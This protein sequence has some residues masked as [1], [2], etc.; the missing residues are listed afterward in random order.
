M[1]SAPPP[2]S[3]TLPPGF[4]PDPARMRKYCF[5]LIR[6]VTGRLGWR[7]KLWI[8]AAVLLSAV[9]LLPPRL[10]QFFTGGSQKLGEATAGDF[11]RNL[12]TFGAA[13]ALC[14]WLS[15]FL[16]G[17]LREWLRLTISN[18]L[19]RD[20][21]QSLSRTRIDKLDSA[22]RGDWM[23]RMTGD[24]H[25][26]EE[27]LTA[28]L[29]NQIQNLTMLVGAAV[30]FFFH[31]GPLAFIPLAA[32]V[33]LAIFNVFV[34]KKMAPT[35]TEARE[36]EGGVFQTMIETFEGLRT[37]RSYGGERFTFERVNLQLKDLF[38]AGMRIIKSMAAL[39]GLNELSGQIVITAILTLVAY[40]IRGGE[41]TV[42][43]A[44][45]Y[46]FFINLFLGAAK[47]LVASAYDWNR[48]FIEGGRLAT[49]LYDEENR[50]EED[51]VSFGAD[52]ES[53]IVPHASALRAVDLEIGYG[54]GAPV[55]S[56]FDFE[57]QTGEIVAIM[58]PSGCGKSTFLESLSG[59][60]PAGSGAF[61]VDLKSGE[62]TRFPQAPT[63][64]SAFVEQQP[65]LFVGT[66][67]DN[68]TL[69]NP[70]IPDEDTWKA[71]DEVDLDG[72]VKKR[73]GLDAVLADRG[74]NLSVGQQYRLALCRA[75]VSGRPF[76]ML[77]E[78]FA[79]LDEESVDR[80]CEALQAEKRA[81]AGVILITH[82]IPE[83]LAPDRIITIGR[84]NE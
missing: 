68:V 11:L 53:E 17:V 30:L 29:P 67:R 5:R 41:L 80:V 34:Q 69:G 48:F 10:L 62:S 31:S 19:R 49:M 26:A 52:F 44:L 28:S 55:I 58:G 82:L 36:I 66:I 46:P 63:K 70:A 50:V 24:L 33:L 81:G 20:A 15:I 45:I 42:E 6:E 7:Y 13:I 35:L 43:D 56:A 47:E 61:E 23:T 72:L 78:P 77:D 39:M 25:N 59:L 16:T 84:G 9:F 75:L 40:Q 54:G 74:R 64:L 60:R 12:V 79:A 32:A 57:I 51:S 8:P 71:L 21:V 22:H 76:L 4:G 1:D 83:K 18:D 27:F 2:D 3:S 65:Y 14:L 73:G 37:I 38:R